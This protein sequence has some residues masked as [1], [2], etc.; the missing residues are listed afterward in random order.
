MHTSDFGMGVG[1]NGYVF[2]TTNGGD[3]WDVKKLEVTGQIFGR[4]ESLHGV[5]IVDT[6]FAV[7]AG[8]GGT[9]FRTYNGGVAWES[10]GYPV[11][12]DAF[13][14]EDVKFVNRNVGWI[15]GLDQDFG[16]D[17]SVY[18]TTDGGT[19]WTQAMNQPSY[20]WAV[21]FVDDQHGWITT[22]GELYFRTTNGG[23]TWLSGTYPLYF[24]SPT[25]SDIQFADQNVGWAVGWYGFVARSTDGGANWT[26]Q[27]IG[28]TEDHIFSIHVVSPNESWMTGREADVLTMRGV[29]YHT[30]NGGTT[31]TREVTSPNPYWGYAITGSGAS[32]WTAGYEGRIHRKQQQTGIGRELNQT[33]A[34]AFRL[35]Q[36]FPN[37]FNPTTAIRYELAKAGFVS[38]KVYD[39]L[40]REVAVLVGE[41]QTPGT[42]RV[43]WNAAGL[44]SG[45]YF[46]RL[47]ASGVSIAKRMIL[48]K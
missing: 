10:I 13:W 35:E 12:P 48:G 43:S 16:H 6:G 23:T 14:I 38:L 4:D 34:T 27:D 8:P 36:N 37:P 33:L 41:N 32:V 22:I 25:V 17:Q 3:R 26:Y 9:V 21:D 7:V 19:T 42:H 46:Y 20:M 30:T 2:K 5:S 18:R 47:S 11:L 39:I 29:V 28:T 1:Q 40:G 24:T 31:W 15:V 44:S 45:G